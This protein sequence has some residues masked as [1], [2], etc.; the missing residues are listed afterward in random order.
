MYD[1]EAIYDEQ[2]FPL[3]EK[4]LTIC[5]ENQIDFIATFCLIEDPAKGD[6]MVSS[7]IRST[8]YENE[9]ISDIREILDTQLK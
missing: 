2:I 7:W 1:K 3:M 9:T 5:R 8:E 6:M 4:I